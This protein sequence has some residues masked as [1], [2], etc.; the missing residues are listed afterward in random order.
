M[1]YA[2]GGTDVLEGRQGNDSLSGGDGNDDFIFAI[3][4]H[5]GGEDGVDVI[6][7]QTDA[8]GDNLWDMDADGDRPPGA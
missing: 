7:R 5:N 1:L 4:G 3:D 8:N 6:H 2:V